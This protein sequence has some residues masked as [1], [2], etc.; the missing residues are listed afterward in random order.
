MFALLR[1]I[2]GI[3]V[4]LA[5]GGTLTAQ[6]PRASSAAETD[7]LKATLRNGLRVVIVRNALGPVVSTDISYLV[8]SRDDPADVPGMAHAQEHMMFRGTK[9][10]ST[11]ELGTVATALGGNFNAQTSDTLTQ[12]QFT[13]PAADLD[14]VLR[15]ESDR[16][17]D[18]LDAQAQ[19]ENERGAIEQE[20]ARDE[21]QP[22]ADFFRT[23]RLISDAGTP[24]GHDG[25]GTR[26]SFDRLT[27]PRI[28]AFHD[29][30]YAPNNA[31]LV[32]AGDIDPARTLGQIRAR[33]ESIPARAVPAHAAAH[34]APL[35][36]T[37]IERGTTL[38][39]PLAL[40]AVR[41][42]GIDS[43]DFLPSFVLQGVLGSQRGLLRGLV[44]SGEALDG[45]WDSL[46][47]V[48]ETQL[49]IATA[50]L[51]PGADPAKAAT[52]LQEI[53]AAYAR[54]GVP[55]ELF[56]STKRRLIADQ[57]LS[58]NSI[59]A[60][61][62]DW[63]TTIALDRE[64]SI[65]R[66]QALI[67]AV[68]LADVDRVAKRYLDMKHAVVGALTPSA[69]ASQSGAA[70]PAQ[71]GSEKPLGS[72][73]PVTH[74]PPW[75]DSLVKN[76]GIPP[77]APMPVQTVLANGITLIVKNETI[78]DSV[79]VFGNVK[80]NPAIQEPVGKEGVS[81]VL[82]EMFKD[83]TQRADRVAFARAQEDADTQLSAGSSFGL[84]TTSRSFER[85][86][87]L[88]A[89]NELEPRFDER[90]F[91][92]ARRR[93][94][95]ELGTA[96][97]STRTLANQR[98]AAILFPAGDPERRE[99]TLATMRAVALEDVKAYYAQTL[100][101]DQTT[102]V[103]VGNVSAD[104]ARAAF[105]R[106]F[107]G[108]HATGA[109]PDLEL[110]A[111]PVNPPGDVR[112]QLPI[113]QSIVQLQQIVPLSRTSAQTYPLLLGTAILGGGSLGPEQSRLFRSLRQNAGL[114]YSVDARYSPRRARSTFNVEY[115]CAP[116]NQ[117]RIGALVDSEIE[118]MKTE[119]VGDFELALAKASIVRQTVLGEASTGSI[120]G[121]LLD[122]ASSGMPFDQ[123]RLDAQRFIASDAKSIQAAF[124]AYVK[125]QNFVRIIE[126]P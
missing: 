7:V 16:M 80:T 66:E 112:L 40:V 67:A 113:S 110:P 62:S 78:S 26:A 50:A 29:T 45:S 95:E 125:P 92:N 36:R 47:Y 93:A 81:A 25:V 12:Y 35:K 75:A 97:N 74:L 48:P 51:R 85:A 27:G 37:V 55:R 13:V 4:L 104:A 30:W 98:A 58:R 121:T 79:F 84:Q 9:N 83:G 126:G 64:P 21:S 106:D 114:V 2:A 54:G 71:Q 6:A 117:A 11:S 107:G 99:P 124:A 15:I 52:R 56:E 42:P 22:G 31:V 24:Y 119:P 32:V 59:S 18:V 111:L 39:Y 118:R 102:V 108:W 90:T 96:L 68:T 105:E 8:G 57:E 49:G 34:F 28:K 65:A 61:A 69:G 46:P 120:G 88:L 87:A 3:A 41:L 122:E 76:I 20:V 91:E 19:W 70:A 43:P 109:L 116:Q 60:L 23:L 72:Q 14:E 94:I 53:L 63:S 86:V 17:R 33:F 82:A 101:P 89:Q 44:D 1:R 123:R 103:V 100:R 115:A 5:L 10:L 38:V 73:P 77:A